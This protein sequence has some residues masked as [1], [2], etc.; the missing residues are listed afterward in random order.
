M[1]T[2]EEAIAALEEERIAAMDEVYRLRAEKA[3][4]EDYIK[5]C[6]LLLPDEVYWIWKGAAALA[7]TANETEG[8]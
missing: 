7:K 1:R 8:K 5:A 6:G 2:T 3:K 4:L